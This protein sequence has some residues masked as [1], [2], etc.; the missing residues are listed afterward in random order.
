M[1]AILPTLKG[2]GSRLV[3]DTRTIQLLLKS[4]Y[5]GHN[6]MSKLPLLIQESTRT[7]TGFVCATTACQDVIIDTKDFSS[8]YRE[9]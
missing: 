7:G 6:G 8:L 3:A 4:R 2:V 1:L 5:G 9:Q